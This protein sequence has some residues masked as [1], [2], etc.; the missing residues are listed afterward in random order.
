MFLQPVISLPVDVYT[1]ERKAEFMLN[2]AITPEEYTTAVEQVRKLGLDP[3]SIP[4]VRM[5]TK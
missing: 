2:N 1:P 3:E 5:P 4:H